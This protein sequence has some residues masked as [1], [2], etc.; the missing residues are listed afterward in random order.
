[1]NAATTDTGQVRRAGGHVPG[2]TAE[3]NYFEPKGRRP[4]H[5]EDMTVDVQPGSRSVTFS[6]T[7]SSHS[8]TAPRPTLRS[9]RRRRVRTGI[10]SAPSIRNGS[11]PLSAAV[12]D[13][14]HGPGRHRERG[15]NWRSKR[16]DKTWVKILQD[17]L[18][19]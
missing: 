14:R 17:H 13:L 2:S 8:R 15:A 5:Y 6:R 19:A 16:M 4:P 12:D 10:S 9:G 11:A 18:G 7:G 3:S 1:M